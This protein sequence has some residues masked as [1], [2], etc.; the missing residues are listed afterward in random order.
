MN[1]LAAFLSVIFLA[2]AINAQ[3]AD[4][5]IA[6]NTLEDSKADDYDVYS[7]NID[8][9]GEKNITKNK[10]VAWTYYAWKD[11]L[12]F[13]SDRGA[14]RRCYFLHESDANGNNMQQESNPQLQESMLGA[15]NDGKALR[16]RRTMHTGT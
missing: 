11:R 4:Y 16:L 2:S 8:G 1:K 14:C 9:S 15:R 12:F 7:M 3:P 13:V 6:F 5:R 10:D